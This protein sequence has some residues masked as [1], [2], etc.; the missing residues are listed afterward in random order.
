MAYEQPYNVTQVSDAGWDYDVPLF[1]GMMLGLAGA[2][3]FIAGISAVLRDDIYI[4]TPGYVFQ[5]S[6]TTWGWLH[7]IMGLVGLVVAIAILSHQAWAMFIGILMAVGSAF[8][9]FMT[10]PIQPL[11]SIVVIVI[12]GIVIWSLART[13]NK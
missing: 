7:L 6:L 13:L 10:M 12:D 1:A 3:Q 5:L 8:V 4:A 9:H 2:F 11:W